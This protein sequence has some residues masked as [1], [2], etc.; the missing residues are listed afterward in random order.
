V[1]ECLALLRGGNVP[2]S[3]IVTYALPIE[4]RLAVRDGCDSTRARELLDQLLSR[5]RDAGVLDDANLAVYVRQCEAFV[6]ELEQARAQARTPLLVG[7]FAVSELLPQL[8][9][10]LLD[11]LPILLPLEYVRL[12]GV[13]GWVD[14]MRLGT[15]GLPVPD[16]RDET[17]V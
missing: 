12:A 16:W 1:V 15:D 14:A 13:A 11:M 5:A 17:G 4:L 2:E 3:F 7:G 6:V 10:A 9:L 8:R